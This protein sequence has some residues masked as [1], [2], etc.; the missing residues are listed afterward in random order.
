MNCFKC[1]HFSSCNHWGLYN[2][3]NPLEV[4]N[5]YEEERGD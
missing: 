5:G 2:Y 3:R 4:C 1:I